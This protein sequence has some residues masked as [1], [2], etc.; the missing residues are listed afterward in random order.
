M[1]SLYTC[2]L[3][4]RQMTHAP[5]TACQSPDHAV[6]TDFESAVTGHRAL[7]PARRFPARARAAAIWA[8]SDFNL[9]CLPTLDLAG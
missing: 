8:Q 6:T 5:P 9:A 2:G 7:L 3:R 4:L 1:S